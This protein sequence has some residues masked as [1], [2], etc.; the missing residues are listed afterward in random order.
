MDVVRL[1]VPDV[2]IERWGMRA[3]ELGLSLTEFIRRAGNFSAAY[4]LTAFS[5]TSNPSDPRLGTETE[6]ERERRENPPPP[7]FTG[8]E[9]KA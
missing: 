9:V 4:S 1:N 5:G 8:Y 7:F 6:A 3:G 2:D